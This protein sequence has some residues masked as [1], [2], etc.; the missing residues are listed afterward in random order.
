MKMMELMA[1][2]PAL[3]ALTKKRFTRFSVARKLAAMRKRVEEEAEF[4]ATEQNKAIMA[5]AALDENGNPIF[6][7]GRRIQLKSP[8]ARVAFERALEALNEMCVDGLSPLALTEA[9]FADTKDFTTPDEMCALMG[10]VDFE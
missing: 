10:L 2:K 4:Y 9:D 5:Y 6:I 7:D 8:E 3:E 1:A